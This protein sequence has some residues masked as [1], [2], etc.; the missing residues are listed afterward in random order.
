MGTNRD[1]LSRRRF[2]AATAGSLA[3]AGLAAMASRVGVGASTSEEDVPATSEMITRTLGRT[4]LQ[5]PV[6]GMGGGACSDPALFQAA[7]SHGVRLFHTSGDYLNGRSEEAL[8]RTPMMAAEA[9][10][11][12]V[13]TGGLAPWQREGKT[14]EQ[15][16]ALLVKLAE[17]SLTR[18]KRDC[19][20]V[21]LVHDVRDAATVRDPF[22]KDGL[23]RL[24]KAGK[25]RFV[26]LASHS[27]SKE[28]V[29]TATTD[30]SYDVL[31]LGMN[32]TVADDPMV[33]AIAD[34]AA[35]GI[36]VLAMKTQVGGRDFSG[37]ENWKEYDLSTMN[38]AAL[39]WVLN[40]P[41]VIAAVPAPGNYE[42]LRNNVAVGRNLTF[43]EREKAFLGDNKIKL[44]FGFCRQCRG[45]LASC[46]NGV[47]IPDLMRVHMYTNQYGNFTLAR[48]TLRNLPRE[49][50][51]AV[52]ANCN[53]C[54]AQ[55]AHAIV[56]VGTRITALL[57]LYG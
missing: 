26:G 51:L 43:T 54:T 5:I 27:V 34:A 25:A 55:C 2:L 44:G 8:A 23:A 11:P 57:E 22:I 37:I 35:A 40:T 6:V 48:T 12:I 24:K 17:E 10:P 41:G 20:D 56:P 36:G 7:Y 52:C 29:E 14:G 28:I 31:L 49:R 18:L 16:T 21:Y 47:E 4:G 32:F 33:G 39:K 45:C 46:P 19:A 1:E 42:H 30:G 38:S 13:V 3:T 53:E 15:K 9:G 50:G